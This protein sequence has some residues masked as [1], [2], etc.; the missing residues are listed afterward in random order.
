MRSNFR[1]DWYV[2]QEWFDLEQKEIFS[3][4]W[5]F[6]C[7]KFMVDE[8]NRFVTRE[9]AGVPIV[10]QNFDGELRAF[11]NICLH[12]QHRLQSEDFGT[13]R[14]VCHY[15]GW[16]YN[17]DG[18]LASVPLEDVYYSL[19]AKESCARL[20]GFHL[21]V[22]GQ[23]VFINL[24]PNP[25]PIEKQFGPSLI[26][27]LESTSESFGREVLIS[28]IVCNFN[29]KLIYETLRDS[30]HPA[31]HPSEDADQGCAMRSRS[32]SLRL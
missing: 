29:W 7:L 24:D 18:G 8:P 1:N 6:A 5:I 17:S 28:K 12:R 26:A 9:I 19:D 30:I 25:L 16:R 14:L 4:Y 3:K 32:H 20:E 23:Y 2:S 10:I 11:R 21:R 31:L 22:I 13:R 27:D 15:H